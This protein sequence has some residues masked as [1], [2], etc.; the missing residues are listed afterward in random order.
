MMQSARVSML[1][2]AAPCETPPIA[3]FSQPPLPSSRTSFR[4]ASSIFASWLAA[5]CAE[6]HASKSL[7]SF[8]C[9]PRKRANRESCCLPFSISLELR[10]LLRDKRVIGAM[11]II[12]RHADCLR[13]RLCIDRLIHTHIPFLVQHL[14]RHAV[15]ER[16][17]SRQF[18]RQRLRILQ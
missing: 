18:R 15:R 6:A 11:K 4:Q 3:Y 16:G 14:F 2:D 12:R 8:R 17:T 5:K 1:S 10:L 9:A 13:L 7:V